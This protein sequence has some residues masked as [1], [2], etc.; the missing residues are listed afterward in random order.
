MTSIIQ[1]RKSSLKPGGIKLQDIPFPRRALL[2]RIGAENV[3]AA[4]GTVSSLVDYETLLKYTASTAG[5]AGCMQPAVSG[6]VDYLQ[7]NLSEPVASLTGYAI[8]ESS[9][10]ISGA[11]LFGGRAALTI[12]ALVA[13]SPGTVGGDYGSGRVI[14]GGGPGGST[15][16]MLKLMF[17]D[18]RTLSLTARKASTAEPVSQVG[19]LDLVPGRFYLV[20]AEI[21]FAENYISLEVDGVLRKMSAFA[22]VP[23]NSVSPAGT[24]MAWFVQ[25][26]GSN[27]NAGSQFNG[28]CREAFIADGILSEVGKRMLR[29]YWRPYQ[30]KMNGEG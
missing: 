17:T 8:S 28:R 23:G 4:N 22:N 11:A 20:I 30:R 1:F 19:M 10:G 27:Q 7:G 26:M 25:R 2:S 18:A 9:G 29:E 21:N 3:Q 6:E 15:V 14:V 13:S 24:G 12:A 16:P 5:L